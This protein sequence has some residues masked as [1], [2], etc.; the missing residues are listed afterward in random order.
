MPPERV[1]PVIAPCVAG[2]AVK[3]EAVPI[4]PDSICSTSWFPAVVENQSKPLALL[5]VSKPMKSVLPT[6]RLP[7]PNPMEM[8]SRA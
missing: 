4:A 8:V 5:E 1:W 7:S 6:P 3:L 2:A